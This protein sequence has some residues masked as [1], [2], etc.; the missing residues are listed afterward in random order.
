M[1]NR[2]RDCGDPI[3]ADYF[4]CDNCADN[5]LMQVDEAI[6]ETRAKAHPTTPAETSRKDTP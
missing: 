5:I 1:T 3:E 2:C 6:A 4:L